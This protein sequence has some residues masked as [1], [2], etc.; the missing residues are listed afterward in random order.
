[1]ALGKLGDVH[2]GLNALL[3]ADERAERQKLDDFA[4]HDLPDRMCSGFAL[5][6]P[7][8]RAPGP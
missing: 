2:Q 8:R 3:D 6:S 4:W 7:R 1:V 5:R